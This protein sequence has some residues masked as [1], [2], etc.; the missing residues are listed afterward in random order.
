[1]TLRPRTARSPA[2]ATRPVLAATTGAPQK[3][4]PGASSVY[5]PLSKSTTAE[6]AEALATCTV[7]APPWTIWDGVRVTPTAAG[8]VDGGSGAAVGGSGAGVGAPAA[9]GS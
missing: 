7:V 2:K 1:M 4:P 6:A 5:W 8:A 9:G 3:A